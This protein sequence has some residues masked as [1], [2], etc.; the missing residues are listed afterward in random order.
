[1]QRRLASLIGTPVSEQ[2]LIVNGTPL[3]PR[4]TL[5]IYK[6]PVRPAAFPLLPALSLL[7]GFNWFLWV[8]LLLCLIRQLSVNQVQQI[9]LVQREEGDIHLW[10]YALKTG[11]GVITGRWMR[12]VKGARCSSTARPI[13]AQML[14]L[15]NPRPCRPSWSTV[16]TPV[17]PHD[18]SWCFRN[19]VFEVPSVPPHATTPSRGA[20]IS[21]MTSPETHHL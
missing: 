19:P 6:L 13:C 5:G 12:L 20:P 7:R 18:L 11:A 8:S 10:E 15:Q 14:H 21:A 2:I 3:D 4:Q 16:S 1:M 9:W 17:W